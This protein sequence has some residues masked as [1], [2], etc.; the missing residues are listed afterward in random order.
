MICTT[1]KLHARYITTEN[2]KPYGQLIQ[3]VADNKYYDFRDAQ[4]N[5][6]KGI[7]RFYI[8]SLKYKK[9]Q[10]HSITRH[11][12][13]TQCL[14]ALDSKIWYIAVA[15]P[16]LENKPKKDN[17]VVF[18]IPSNCFIK[19][20]VG[21]WH[22]GPYFDDEIVNFY[23]LELSDTNVNDHFSYNFLVNENVQFTIVD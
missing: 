13:C 5:L 10:F 16:T 7:P 23:N 8:M 21:T 9:K 20:E 18:K 19:L 11:N 3:P 1:Y 17:L 14:G 2:F 12:F 4:L 22:S 15:S 6:S